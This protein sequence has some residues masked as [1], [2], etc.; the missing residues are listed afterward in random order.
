MPNIVY[1]GPLL[2]NWCFQCNIPILEMEN[3][4]LCGSPT[5][6]CKI[7]PPGDTRPAFAHDIELIR[8]TIDFQYGAGVGQKLIPDKKLVVLNK[9]PAL[10]RRNE[11][12]LDGLI[13]GALYF[14]YPI[15]VFFFV[16]INDQVQQGKRL[17]KGNSRLGIF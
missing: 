7:T 17:K 1:L 15:D 9:A 5:T 11:I 12:I 10:D 4:T 6:K 16:V 8:Q 3:C 14:T 13:I 2:L